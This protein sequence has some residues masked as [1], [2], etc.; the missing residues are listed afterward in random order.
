MCAPDTGPRRRHETLQVDVVRG[1]S[2]PADGANPGP[3]A[4]RVADSCD[5]CCKLALALGQRTSSPAARQKFCSRS[6]RHRIGRPSLKAKCRDVGGRLEG[7]SGPI[8]SRNKGK[9]GGQ[10]WNWTADTGFP[11]LGGRAAP[12]RLCL[13][14]T[15]V[16]GRGVPRSPPSSAAGSSR[17][18]ELLIG[19]DRE[20][21]WSIAFLPKSRRRPAGTRATSSQQW[22]CGTSTCRGSERR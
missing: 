6:S 21:A 3:G 7:S 17:P 18:V 10:G 11:V 19:G 8:S 20:R 12:V 13:E 15:G 1:R 4:D 22:E 14:L 16:E 9:I 5:R 2:A